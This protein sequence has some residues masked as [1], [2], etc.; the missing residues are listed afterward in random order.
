MTTDT[1]PSPTQRARATT[2]E[3]LWWLALLSLTTLLWCAVYNR[4]S[5]QAWT[6]PVVYAG[7]TW[8][9]MA[10]AKALATGDTLPI[11]P[12]FPRSFGAPF[13]AN[14]NDYP[15]IEEGI[16]VWYAVFI[17]L[18]GVFAGSNLA[19]LSAHLLAAVS[20]Y[21]VSRTLRYQR[22]ISFALAILFAMSP[23]AFTRNLGHLVLTFYWHVPLGLLV[24][25]WC[26]TGQA[27]ATTRNRVFCM[28]VCVLHGIQYMYY[29][30]IFCQ[31]LLVAAF[32]G[33]LRREKPSQIFFPLLL[34]G[35]VFATFLVM[36][37][38]TLYYRFAHGPNPA[39]LVRTYAG[40]E[41]YALRPVEL[42]LPAFH[43]IAWL[44]RWT[45]NN[46]Y[47]QTMFQRGENDSPYLG[48]VAIAA[49]IWIVWV[50]VRAVANRRAADLPPHAWGIGWIFAFSV[51]GGL[52]GMIGVFGLVFFRG[53]NRYSLVI[54]AIALLFLGRELS[55]RARSWPLWAVCAGAA[56]LLFFGLADQVARLTRSAEIRQV[57]KVVLSDAGLVA[58]LESKLAPDSMIFQLPVADYPEI[59][60]IERMIDYE[61]MRPYLHS[62]SLRFSYGSQ[63]GRTR[64]AWQHEVMALGAATA[65]AQLEHY[66]FAAVLINRNGYADG[67]TSVLAEFQKAGRS[68]IL[69]Q[70]DDFV[71]IALH[72]V[73]HPTLPPEFDRS[74]YGFEGNVADH[75]R[76][77]MGD[78]GV[79][80]HCAPGDSR[81]VQLAFNLGSMAPQRV[82]IYRGT[83]KLYST[84]LDPGQPPVAVHLT[85][86]L[87][88]GRNELSFRTDRPAQLPGNGDPRK[89]AFN[90]RN[91]TILD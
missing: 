14:W 38:D 41:V 69:S 43:R 37:A 49:L 62:H 27:N 1:F 87:A 89:L 48:M 33:F 54:A 68:E 88:Q 40:L 61:H 28:V 26:L 21:F 86:A 46:Y 71:S 32:V 64:E 2:P 82:E 7:D 34:I 83:E 5:V 23:Y 66:G 10:T 78:A 85:V 15:S 53:T 4:W 80:L 16:F 73:A 19:L 36:S 63:K 44:Q 29:T 25:W 45:N 84:A 91:F 77:S 60:P 70:S 52:N 55:R 17:W 74:W 72:P 79:I 24:A 90:I 39:A 50:S 67:A 57:R 59:G 12:K 8:A 13:V 11:L 65:V 20:F 9:S 6:T 56:G 35:V 22:V 3:W 31:F 51:I 18:F 30:G 75:W 76:W 42:F 58:A 81:T 47:S